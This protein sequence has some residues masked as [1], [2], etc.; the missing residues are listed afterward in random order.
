MNMEQTIFSTFAKPIYLGGPSVNPHWNVPR[1]LKSLCG[2]INAAQM[3]VQV[4][5][6]L[7]NQR[8]AGHGEALNELGVATMC[9][10]ATSMIVERSIKT[11]IAQTQ[12][13]AKPPWTHPLVTLF[14]DHLGSAYQGL[15]QHHLENLPD[16]WADYAETS[17]VLDI[18]EIASDNFVRWRYVAEA[19][20]ANN[21]IPKPLLKVGVALTLAGVNLLSEWQSSNGN[22]NL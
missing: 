4:H 10:V 17:S 13:D 16:V 11:L 7:L 9:V 15:A 1:Q 19:E 18:V 2:E 12:P 8:L 6:P 14:K 20:G 5:E 22:S 21:G 3:L